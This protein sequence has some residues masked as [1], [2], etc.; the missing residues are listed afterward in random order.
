MRNVLILVIVLNMQIVLQGTTEEYAS[1]NQA[2][3]EIRMEL[4]ALLVR[5]FST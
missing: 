5:V 1:V 2:I 3:L 4:L